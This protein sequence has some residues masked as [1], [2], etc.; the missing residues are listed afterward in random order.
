MKQLSKNVKENN[1]RKIL[2]LF[3]KLKT[4]R[5]IISSVHVAQF[6]KNFIPDEETPLNFNTLPDY[7]PSDMETFNL[8]E[9]E[10][11]LK[12]VLEIRL[13]GKAVTLMYLVKLKFLD[14]AKILSTKLLKTIETTNKRYLDSLQAFCIF[15]KSRAFEL[16]GHLRDLRPE[17]FNYYRKACIKADEIGQATVIN[18][19]LRNFLEFFHFS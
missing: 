6:Y 19:I 11:K 5:A 14:Q 10:K 15:Y 3:R 12:D 7:H 18:L 2:L 8:N 16:S 17:L 13:F 4:Y 1:S 9:Q